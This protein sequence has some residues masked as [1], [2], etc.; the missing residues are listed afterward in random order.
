MATR[1]EMILAV[2]AVQNGFMNQAQVQACMDIQR[3]LAEKGKEI[4]LVKIF[5]K[6]KLLDEAQLHFLATGEGVALN[7]EKA[8]CR[9][10]IPG[11]E[12]Y[13]KIGQGGMASVYAAYSDK[14]GGDTVALKVLFPH[15]YRNQNFV[16]GFL[17][18]AKMLSELDHPNLVRGFDYGKGGDLY[19]MAI[20]LVDGPSVQELLDERG[21]LEEDL[22]LHIILRVARA[23]KYLGSQGITHRDIKP[24]NMLMAPDGE[25][26]LIDLGF[27]KDAETEEQ[28]G[29]TCGT[30]QYISP[31]QAR[32]RTDVDIRS[33]IYSLG[34]TL[35]H[36]VIG[37]VPFGGSDSMDVMAKQVLEE[38]SSDKTKSGAI[39]HHMHYFIEKMMAKERDIRYQSP[40]EVIEDIESVVEGNRSLA[41]NPDG[42]GPALDLGLASKPSS[43]RRRGSSVNL[44]AARGSESSRTTRGRTQAGA[45][46]RRRKEES[47]GSD[48]R[49][50]RD[51]GA[52][53]KKRERRRR[54]RGKTETGGS[55]LDRLKRR[56]GG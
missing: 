56:R 5:Q 13:E 6:K 47:A 1:E 17:N 30:V 2:K 33:D 14:Q 25:M 28:E 27:A 46:S 22:A 19:Y 21:K 42:G 43:G 8:E 51:E 38:L 26:K 29:V 50:R 39:S 31:E 55:I 12:M 24:D 45:R 40:S 41:F 54:T 4:S 20:E 37:E 11:Y 7:L 9:E 18:E 23:L 10:A 48:R 53:D 35:Y 32:G 34:A 3:T 16:E 36:L 49:R 15:H 44:R 52:D